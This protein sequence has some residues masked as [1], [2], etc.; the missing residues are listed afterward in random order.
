MRKLTGPS[1][2]LVFLLAAAG[3]TGCSDQRNANSERVAALHSIKQKPEKSNIRTKLS[4]PADSSG[5]SSTEKDALFEAFL[6]W[7]QRLPQLYAK[8]DE[9]MP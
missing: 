1:T 2:L 4:H 6:I 7:R 9:A 5:L 3:A 8:T